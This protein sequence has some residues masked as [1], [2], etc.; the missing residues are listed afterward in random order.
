MPLWTQFLI[1]IAELPPNWCLPGVPAKRRDNCVLHQ[2]GMIYHN[3]MPNSISQRHAEPQKEKRNVVQWVSTVCVSRMGKD[4][5]RFARKE[6]DLRP[7]SPTLTHSG[8]TDQ[9]CLLANHTCAKQARPRAS[10][11]LP[12]RAVSSPPQMSLHGSAFLGHAQKQPCAPENF[13]GP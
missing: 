1:W 4:P 13:K 5:W 2:R 9:V 11:P 7:G 3:G 12:S 8:N 6:M 10:R